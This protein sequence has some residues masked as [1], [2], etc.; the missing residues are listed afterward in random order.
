[1]IVDPEHDTM[2]KK[3]PLESPPTYEEANHA[4]SSRHPTPLSPPRSTQPLPVLAPTLYNYMNPVT[5]QLI[6]TSLPPEHPEM[7]CLQSG[8]HVTETKYGLLGVL[9]AIFW[10]PIG[11]GLCILDRR[12]KCVRCGVIFND[13]L[14]T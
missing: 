8:K 14:C 7:I 5:K 13:G 2:T 12:V 10:F 3:V 9:A 6:T 1:M 11:I 4:S